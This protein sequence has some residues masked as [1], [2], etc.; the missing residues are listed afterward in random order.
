MPTLLLGT[1]LIVIDYAW[2]VRAVTWGESPLIYHQDHSH[3]HFWLFHVFSSVAHV[4]LAA[5]L[6]LYLMDRR[7]RT[8]GGP[9]QP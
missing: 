9:A 3:L 2:L 1:V 8:A 6:A 7:A 4:V 5:G